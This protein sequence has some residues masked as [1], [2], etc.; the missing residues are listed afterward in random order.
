MKWAAVLG[1]NRDSQL[2]DMFVVSKAGRCLD[3]L[4]GDGLVDKDG[5]AA[6]ARVVGPIF[7]DHVVVWCWFE[8]G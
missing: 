3:L 5:D 8:F 7:P 4:K 6:A 2:F 1:L